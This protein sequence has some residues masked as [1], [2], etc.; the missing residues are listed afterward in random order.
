VVIVPIVFEKE[1]EIIMKNAE[2]LRETLEKAGIRVLL[3]DREETAGRKF[4]DW[5]IKGAPLRAEIG[6]DDIKKN[7]VIIVKR[8]DG[9]KIAIKRESL[10]SEVNSLMKT[11][12]EELLKK[13]QKETIERI[14][15]ADSLKKMEE[16]LEKGKCAKIHWCKKGE[17]YDRVKT[18]KEGAEIFGSDYYEKKKG[19]CAACD[20]E[21]DNLA[22]V[23]KTY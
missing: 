21:T 6:P 11:I 13:S 1:K 15:Y 10:I 17:C 18:V 19:R 5:E 4:Y 16:L 12:Q 23:A 3:D 2:T 20:E 14:D 9:K 8:N 7:Q 22:Y